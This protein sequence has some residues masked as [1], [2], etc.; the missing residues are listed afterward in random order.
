MVADDCVKGVFESAI[1]SLDSTTATNDCL[2]AYEAVILVVLWAILVI[3]S[4]PAILSACISWVFIF[5]F[6]VRAFHPLCFW[7][8]DFIVIEALQ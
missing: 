7:R 8:L 5:G 1:Y 4:I 2:K 3:T 6:L